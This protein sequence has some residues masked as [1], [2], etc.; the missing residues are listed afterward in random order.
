MSLTVSVIVP[1]YNREK[2]I[3]ACVQSVLEQS[4]QDFEI[5]LVDDGS[6]D[7][8]V[9]I[10]QKLTQKDSRIKL[11]TTKHEGVSAARNLALD[12]ACGEYLFFLDSDDAIHPLTLESLVNAAQTHQVA[13][14]AVNGADVPDAQWD[15][16]VPSAI[17]LCSSLENSKIYSNEMLLEAFFHRK[18]ALGRMGSILMQRSYVADTRFRKDLSI[19]ED[20]W[21]IYQN[22]L[23]GSG[24]VIIDDSGYY[25]RTHPEKASLSITYPAFCSRWLCKEL[26]WKSEEA[27]GRQN[28]ADIEKMAHAKNCM[29]AQVNNPICGED[30]R[31]IRQHMRHYC[32]D[33]LPVLHGK[34]RR[35]YWLT[36]NAP[37]LVLPYLKRKKAKKAKSRQSS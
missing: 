19:G 1:V 34:P 17:F 35:I 25:W 37:W 33:I 12:H 32:K 27:L 20:V 18:K 3:E 5:L 36:M 21:F 22:I 10:C 6:T 28:Y 16:Y 7:H 30:S 9:E 31:K 11:Y 13:I 23:K 29:A 8:S 26:L 2:Y 14:A 24:G 4:L 15:A